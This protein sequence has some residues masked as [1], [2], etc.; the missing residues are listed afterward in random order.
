MGKIIVSSS[1][2]NPQLEICTD[3]NTSSTERR[4]KLILK[5]TST[6]WQAL[7]EM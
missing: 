5:Y 6:W 3:K 2:N 4:K 7:E 1:I